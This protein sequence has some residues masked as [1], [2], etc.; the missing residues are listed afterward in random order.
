MD[1][2]L[3]VG[4][5]HL[6]VPSLALEIPEFQLRCQQAINKQVVPFFFFN[7][8]ARNYYKW[9]ELSVYDN[10][11]SSLSPQLCVLCP[12]GNS[13]TILASFTFFAR[14][15]ITYK[16][17]WTLCCLYHKC[18][19]EEGGVAPTY[20]PH[21]SCIQLS[22]FSWVLIFPEFSDIFYAFSTLFSFLS[23]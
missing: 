12:M 15:F 14:N 21:Y 7:R 3:G 6:R 13:M 18:G 4:I 9:W 8:T 11:W 5:K 23:A 10:S 20:R 17:S 2:S 22:T 16:V 1:P 19:R